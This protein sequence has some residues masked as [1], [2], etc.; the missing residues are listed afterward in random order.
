MLQIPPRYICLVLLV[1]QN[2]VT[3]FSAAI[4]GHVNESSQTLLCVDPQFVARRSSE[5]SNSQA[6]MVQHYLLLQRND[7]NSTHNLLNIIS[8]KQGKSIV[9]DHELLRNATTTHIDRRS[10]AVTAAA[11]SAAAF[12]S[13]SRCFKYLVR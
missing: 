13:A 8:R 2:G 9:T 11:A 10:Q 4:A 12:L 5:E 7:P 6:K 1:Y 3:S